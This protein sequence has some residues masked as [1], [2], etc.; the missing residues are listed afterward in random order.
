VVIDL[1]DDTA[2]AVSGGEGGIDA[3]AKAA[4]AMGIGGET[5]ISATSMGIAPLSNSS[6]I[7]L[8]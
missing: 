6:S 1:S 2:R 7:S 4:K 8:R 3:N 5:S